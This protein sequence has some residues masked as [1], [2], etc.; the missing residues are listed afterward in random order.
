MQVYDRDGVICKK[1]G[2][3]VTCPCPTLTW[4]RA[5]TVAKTGATLDADVFRQI[6][7]RWLGQ[8]NG[9]GR[10]RCETRGSNAL[11]DA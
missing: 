2:N 7:G 8:A 1:H 3:D 6:P 10:D 11:S 4:A 9:R 5:R